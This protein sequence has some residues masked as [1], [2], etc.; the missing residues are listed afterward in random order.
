M[1]KE[2]RSSTEKENTGDITIGIGADHA[3][4]ALKQFLCDVLRDWE[5][6]C[7]DMGTHSEESCD[8]P[9][10]ARPVTEGVLNG[11]FTRGILICGTG[12]GMS[13]AA[14]RLPSIRGTICSDTYDAEVSRLHNN[15]N[16]LIL[17]ARTTTKEMAEK[18]LDIWLKTDFDSRGRHSRRLEKIE[19]QFCS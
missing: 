13:I 15:S 2:N 5:I 16:V 8:Y 18:I 10:Y 14:N 1:C 12:I 7:R 3:G 9:D 17:G 4:F 6:S 11:T 19:S